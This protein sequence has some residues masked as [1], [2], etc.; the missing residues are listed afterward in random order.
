MPAASNIDNYYIGKGK[1]YWTPDGGTERELGNVPEFEFTPSLEK[2]DHFS[3]QAGVRSEDRSVVLEKSAQLRIL[4]EEWSV[5]NL[6]LQLMG[7]TPADN[8]SGDMEFDLLAEDEIRGQIRFVGANSVG[9][10]V[11]ITL[12]LVSFIPSSGVS[13][14]GDE[15]GT[16]ELSG[17][18][19]TSAG[20]FGTV[21]IKEPA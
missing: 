18:V 9:P 20:S 13:L 1:V 2:L 10:Q 11:T 19:L 5:E 15:W 8:G 17:E 21:T 7:D 6:A 12:P 3:S 4:M 14:I 16:L